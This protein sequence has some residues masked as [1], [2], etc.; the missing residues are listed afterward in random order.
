MSTAVARRSQSV[1]S[2]R[3][4]K[5]QGE[6][7]NQRLNKRASQEIEDSNLTVIISPVSTVTIT[8]K[9]KIETFKQLLQH[10]SKA[11][12]GWIRKISK[13]CFT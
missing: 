11:Q 4:L 13:V 10:W 12:Q 3:V 5:K 9:T 6:T 2:F 1:I 8:D 7:S